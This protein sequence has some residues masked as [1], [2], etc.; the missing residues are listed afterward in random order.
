M[1]AEAKLV[2]VKKA[3]IDERRATKS[4]MPDDLVGK[5]TKRELRDLMEFLSGLKAEWKK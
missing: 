5:L 4:A 1:T 3:D 2:V